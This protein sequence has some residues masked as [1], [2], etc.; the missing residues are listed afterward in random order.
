L[1]FRGAKLVKILYSEAGCMLH[2]LIKLFHWTNNKIK[3]TVFS[4]FFS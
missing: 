2:I 1:L 3:L 4:F